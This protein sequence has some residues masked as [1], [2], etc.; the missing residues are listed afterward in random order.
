[1][2]ELEKTCIKSI[3]NIKIPKIGKI[4]GVLASDAKNKKNP[5][6]F[7]YA[8]VGLDIQDFD[9][10]A[11]PFIR[12]Y[13]ETN[14]KEIEIIEFPPVRYPCVAPKLLSDIP[15]FLSYDKDP[16][17]RAGQEPKTI[18]TRIEL[19]MPLLN[20]VDTV[21]A[22]LEAELETKKGEFEKKGVLV[23]P[24]AW[25]NI[26][27]PNDVVYIDKEDVRDVFWTVPNGKDYDN[28]NSI[29]AHAGIQFHL[30]TISVPF[31]LHSI[32]THVV[33]PPD[34]SSADRC[35][36]GWKQDLSDPK[37]VDIYAVDQLGHAGFGGCFHKGHV[38]IEGASHSYFVTVGPEE[39]AILVAHE[40]GHYLGSLCHVDAVAKDPSKP[41]WMPCKE[42]YN[43]NVNDNLMTSYLAGWKLEVGQI[44]D[45]RKS[46]K[47]KLKQYGGY[48]M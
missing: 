48:W 7:K 44:Q 9:A 30:T 14:K 15:V 8:I 31:H 11:P 12:I 19:H 37:A 20:H 24:V 25:H 39:R 38:L 3:W 23:V 42:Q 41:L 33:S 46:L 43:A 47:S 17:N 22:K 4:G 18:I 21:Y 13:D 10:N 45:L 6:T 29:F 27:E 40:F 5:P 1:M 2:V 26:I 32:P 34:K 36:I 35:D 28:I 16:W